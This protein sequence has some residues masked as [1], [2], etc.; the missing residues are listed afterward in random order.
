MNKTET[1]YEAI[2]PFKITFG[3]DKSDYNTKE[4]HVLYAVTLSGF[5][6]RKSYRIYKS[7]IASKEQHR[8]NIEL[9]EYLLTQWFYSH[10]FYYSQIRSKWIRFF[11][12]FK[13]KETV[14]GAIIKRLFRKTYILK[15]LEVF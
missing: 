5:L 1:L 10:I 11:L 8:R 4:E 13:R 15:L 14:E 3:G 12:L 7:V 2:Q 9:V 6:V